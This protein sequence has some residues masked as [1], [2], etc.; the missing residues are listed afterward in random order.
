MRRFRLILGGTSAV[1]A[2][3]SHGA[4]AQPSDEGA[5]EIRAAL[6]E[7]ITENL[8]AQSSEFQIVFDDAIE[9]APEGDR[10][11]VLIPAA[12]MTFAGEVALA[13][14]PI[15]GTALPLDNGWYDVEWVLPDRYVVGEIGGGDSV[16][17]TVGEQFGRGTL[18]PEYQTFMDFEMLLGAIRV[19]PPDNAG[20][21]VVDRITAEADY[22]EV[23]AGIFDGIGEFVMEGL[24][25]VDSASGDTV[26][27]AGFELTGEMGRVRMDEYVAFSR[28]VNELSTL[29]PMDPDSGEPPT[30]YLQALGQLITDAPVLFDGFAFEY[31]IN[32]FN[33]DADG[34]Q[35]TSEASHFGMAL[36]GLEGD[37]SDLSITGGFD[38]IEVMPAPPMGEF[39]PATGNL[40]ISLNG[41]P[42][43]A[44]MQALTNALQGSA[45][46]NPE[47]A[48]MMAVSAIQQAATQAGTS[49]QINDVS[50]VGDIYKTVLTGSH[51]PM[52]APS[53]ARLPTS[54]SS[55]PTS[56]A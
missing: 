11:R 3:L 16:E 37:M 26:N 41:V 15:T 25:F 5:E 24:E 38:T 30:A 55:C 53:W 27:V 28:E 46:A 21:I 42:N 12:D 44:I 54:T 47:M 22:D 14:D 40:D 43:G 48:V 13:L 36:E 51:A 35:V 6:K 32:G 34:T 10:Y 39:I 31:T 49:I 1:L 19:L 9:V 23:E 29:Y 8:Q 2:L 33:V 18:A 17:V 56:T 20:E 4:L 45:T 52:S 50:I 7:W